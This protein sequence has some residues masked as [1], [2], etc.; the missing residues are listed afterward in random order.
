M[1]A[2]K[3][4]T[5]KII[6]FLVSIELLE[7]FSQFCFKKSVIS[8]DQPQMANIIDAVSFI[9]AVIPS[10][11]LW[12]GLFAV[13]VIFISWAAVLSRVDLSVAVPICSF[14]YITVPIVSMIFF[15]ERISALR[16]LGI[17]LI[18]IGVILVSLSSVKRKE[19]TL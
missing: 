19:H 18:L 11:F 5:F 6:L 9:R 10:P 13:L 3:H 17:C 8:I 2:K 15:H 14:S 16:W 7:T 12:A 4:I 1:S